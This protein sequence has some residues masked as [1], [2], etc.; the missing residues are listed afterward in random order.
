MLQVSADWG[1]MAAA[2]TGGRTAR[3]QA[4][5]NF[6][7]RR[8]RTRLHG[9]AAASGSPPALLLVNLLHAR[10]LS[11]SPSGALCFS[12]TPL[13]SQFSP[14]FPILLTR[15]PAAQNRG[16]PIRRVVCYGVTFPV[17]SPVPAFSY[18]GHPRMAPALLDFDES[19]AKSMTSGRHGSKADAIPI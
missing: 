19:D 4:G 15:F 7:R 3:R 5:S 10:S 9:R 6:S 14:P 18:R 12:C 11:L 13:L 1:N 2:R 8:G 16:L 17:L